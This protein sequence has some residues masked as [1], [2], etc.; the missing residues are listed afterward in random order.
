MKKRY[1]S[2]L[3]DSQ[4]QIIEKIINDKRKRSR[5]SIREIFNAILYLVTTGCQWRMLPHDFAPWETV[6]YHYSRLLKSGMIEEIHTALRQKVRLQ[7]GR[8]AEPSCCI[9]DSQSVKTTRSGSE[10]RGIDGG[11]KVK[12]RKRHVVCDTTGLILTVKVHAANIHD[13]Q[14]ALDILAEAK[15][16]STRLEA[17]Y[18]DGGYRGELVEKVR[19]SLNMAMNIVLRTWPDKVFKPLPKRWVVERTF[20]WFESF[21]RLSKDYE[22]LNLSCQAMIYLSMIRLMLNKLS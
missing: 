21:R 4:W 7:A 19:Q 8:Q 22:L 2:D 20:S 3:T 11:K 1:S 14:A 17:V 9:I 10:E 12:G 5:H 16:H 6:Y 13:S 15:T 18:A